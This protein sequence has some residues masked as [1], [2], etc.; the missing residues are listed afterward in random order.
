MGVAD[1]K[2]GYAWPGTYGHECG[3]TGTVA[4]AQKSELT[5]SGIFYAIRCDECRR[6]TGRDN[7]GITTWEPFDPAK[8]VN[9]WR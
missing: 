9:H 4:G 8:H 5:V 3:A 6:H 1:R 7:W 2:C